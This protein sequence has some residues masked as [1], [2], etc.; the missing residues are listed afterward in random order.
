M[1]IILT[2]LFCLSLTCIRAKNNYHLLV[3]TYTTSGKSEGIYVYDLNPEHSV[4]TQKFI[5]KGVQNPSYLALTADRKYLYSVNQNA[6]DATISAFAFDAKSGT[7][8]FINKVDAQGKG[9]CYITVTDRHVITANYTS[10]SL[11][12]F[13]RKADGSLTDALQ[14]IQH[15]GSSINPERQATPHVHQ[16]IFSPNGQFLAV[17]DLGTDKVTIYNYDKAGTTRCARETIN[18]GVPESG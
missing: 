12:V 10:G 5:A 17:N 6:T 4:F 2:L 3:G 18:D 14:V 13:G 8:S 11:C 9:P 7:I 16:T 15:T 1:R